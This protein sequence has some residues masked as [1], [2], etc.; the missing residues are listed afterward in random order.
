MLWLAGGVRPTAL[1]PGLLLPVLGC[2]CQRPLEPWTPLR[3]AVPAPEPRRNAFARDRADQ[4]L[5]VAIVV[6]CGPCRIDACG[7]RRFRHD[8][9]APY[10]SENILLADDAVAVGYEVFQQ[11]KHLGLHRDECIPTAEFTA[12]WVEDKVFKYWPRAGV[13]DERQSGA[14]MGRWPPLLWRPN[15]IACGLTQT[16]EMDPS[17]GFRPVGNFTRSLY[18]PRQNRRYH[19]PDPG[20]DPDPGPYPSAPDR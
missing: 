8:A 18:R 4:P 13:G 2:P 15:K 16:G 7:K 10:G 12:R 17:P 6:N 5:L 3:R 20:P 1:D 11:V 9:P 14:L 19:H